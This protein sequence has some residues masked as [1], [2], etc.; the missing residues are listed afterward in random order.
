MSTPLD[1]PAV[2]Q[3][4][5]AGDLIAA[6]E[7]LRRQLRRPEISP[8]DRAPAGPVLTRLLSAAGSALAPPVRV[9]VLAQCSTGW[10]A[11]ALPAAA[12][13]QGVVLSVQEGGY[14]QVR[15]AVEA[16]EAQAPPDVLVLLP[17][18]QRLLHD[19]DSGESQ[20][21]RVADEVAFWSQVWR[22]AATRGVPRIVQVGY[23]WLEPGAAG[24][25]LGTGSTGHLRNVQAANEA[26]QGALPDATA[27]VPLDAISGVMGRHRFYDRRQMAWT[28]QPFSAAGVALLAEHL[29]A[30]IRAL[31]TGPRKLLVV[32]LDD[33]LWG[34]VV[35]E[36]G[37]TGVELGDSPRG[38]AFR[39][40]QR[41][42][43]A[44]VRRGVL[45]AVC[46]KNNREDALG[47]F[48]RH[49]DMVLRLDDI[50][51]FHANWEPKVE[52][53]QHIAREL[54]L[55]LDSIVFFDDSAF[56]RDA[57]RHA[58]PEVEVV[59]VPE[60]PTEYVAALQAG[61]WFES[62]SLTQADQQRA[63]QYKV[64]QQQQTAADTAPDLEAF[65]A[66]L[67][68]RASTRILSEEDL[69]R[70]VQLLG[71]TNQF[72]LT[73][74]R[75]TAAALRSLLALPGMIALTLRLVDRQL[76]HGLVALAI[77]IPDSE[78]GASTMRVDVL[79]M[80]CRVIGRTVEDHLVDQ[81][82]R[83]AAAAGFQRIVGEFIQSPKNALVAGLYP[84]LGFTAEGAT[85]GGGVLF[86]QSL[87]ELPVSKSHVRE[88]T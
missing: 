62:V 34:G 58:L 37:A 59:D 46:S 80:S 86:A 18:N 70:A 54:R 22:L 13:R 12:W 21:K 78:F 57:V 43:R 74:R 53:L 63:A 75:H 48:E 56:E 88:D 67:Q 1:L 10:L 51:C 5:R 4:E 47:P 68:M 87:V 52:N 16:I 8:P 41:H 61:L 60:D 49:P 33:T 44:L 69:P 7:L 26:L 50:A 9:L 76:D 19:E 2:R 32:D 84:R 30:A 55:G 28:R 77:A 29:F 45:L 71:K 40:F 85:R 38:E 83:R 79:L 73:T 81:L 35:G 11:Q 42:L 24:Y 72:N 6:L 14:D 23:D 82:L 31:T 64:M 27:F 25:L 39:A 65:L 15:Q 3:L 66:G 36:L 17:W 20:G